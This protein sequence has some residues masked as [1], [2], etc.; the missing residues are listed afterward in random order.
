MVMRIGGLSSGMDIDSIVNDLMRV[1]R[2]PLDRLNQQKQLLEWQRDDYREMN[3]LLSE[4]D[5]TIFNGIYKQASFTKKTIS[6]SNESAVTA[7]S[8]G[9]TSNVNTTIRV[10]QLAEAAY[11]NSSGDIR[12]NTN[13]DP[14]GILSDQRA[15]LTNDFTSNTFTIQAIR[16]DG[17]LGDA[18]EFTIDPSTDSLN[19]IIQ[20]INNSSAGV[21]AFYDEQTGRI[22]M[23]AKNT[24]DVS[25]DAE[26]KVTGDFLTGSLNLDATNILAEASGNGNLGKNALFQING[27]S[28]ER[29]SNTFTISGFEYSLKQVTSSS[30][31]I[32]SQTDTDTIYNTIVNFVEKYNQMIETINSKISEERYRSYMPLTEDQKK[33]LSDREIELWEAK[34]KSGMLR[35][36]SILSGALSQMRMNFYNKVEGI[37]TNYDHLSEIGIT[38]SNNYREKGKLI[39]D[40]AKLKEAISADPMK[41]YN[42]F[43]AEVKDTDGNLVSEQSGIA[44]RLRNTIK[45]SISSI[46]ARAG[47]SYKNYSQYTLGQ[48]LYDI[49]K[50][51]DSLEERL[52]QIEDRYWRQFTAMEQAIQKANEQST[53]LAQQFG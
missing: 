17:T 34:A 25:S 14:N 46:E 42:L 31:T 7:K 6:S 32:T 30:V 47:N 18:V 3:T 37:D 21:T 5:K 24:G 52:I 39:I 16:S 20:R 50:R 35:N 40:E 1:K 44:K 48:N 28:T 29:T 27:L 15:N 2:L 43:N 38:T 9:S 4:L 13:F 45:N 51:I 33:D 53:Y 19:S 23:T 22:S 12:A 49:A 11:M 8:L 36:D 10:D 41:V 26:I